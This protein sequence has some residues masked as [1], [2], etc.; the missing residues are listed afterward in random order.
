VETTSLIDLETAREA[1]LVQLRHGGGGE[2][3]RVVCG[4]LACNRSMC[5]PLLDAL[6]RVLLIPMRDG[7]ASIMLRELLQVGVRDAHVGRAL[8]RLHA[9][10]RKNWTVEDLAQEAA[11]SRSALADRF[12]SLVGEPPMQYLMRWR[13][14]LAATGQRASA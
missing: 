6:L 12:V 10:P 4:F 1:N 5:R 7:P 9:E 14:T 2:A 8:A 13:L 11:L 3:T